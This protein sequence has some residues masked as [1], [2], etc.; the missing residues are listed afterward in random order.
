M[1]DHPNIELAV[2]YHRAVA[3]GATGTSLA[4]Y[5]HPD[6]VQRELPNALVPQGATRNLDEILAAA[7]RGRQVIR[8]QR[9]EFHHA[10]ATGDQVALE[11]TWIGVLAVPVGA[12]A[13]G[14]EMRAEIATF[15][16][17]RDGLI[18]EQR[19]YDCYVTKF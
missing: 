15:L 19:N 18:V 1:P 11:V 3:A 7:E 16:T 9:F 8:E 14:S 17:I 4:A 13:A 12:L 2:R 5:F 10:A 6:V